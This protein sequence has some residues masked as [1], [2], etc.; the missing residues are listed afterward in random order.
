MRRDFAGR[1]VFVG[2]LLA[3][4]GFLAVVGATFIVNRIRASPERSAQA[5]IAALQKAFEVYQADM[6]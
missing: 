6:R 5:E 2:V 1:Q 3:I 4:A